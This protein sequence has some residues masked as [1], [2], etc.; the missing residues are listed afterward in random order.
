MMN[1]PV[2][3]PRTPR[4]PLKKNSTKRELVLPKTLISWE[5]TVRDTP[6]SKKRSQTYATRTC[7]FH[8]TAPGTGT[9]L[10]RPTSSKNAPQ[11]TQRV[12]ATRRVLPSHLVQ[13]RMVEFSE[14]YATP[15]SISSRENLRV[16]QT[17]AEGH[18]ILN[19]LIQS[20]QRTQLLTVPES[21]RPETAPPKPR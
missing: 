11:R 6:S 17:Q 1:Y 12:A 13:F 7:Y 10:H 3:G 14:R 9:Y 15:A 4:D 19:Q 2:A 18:K 16:E 8:L 21:N 20:P 5:G